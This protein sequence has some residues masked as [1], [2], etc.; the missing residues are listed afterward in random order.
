MML[1]EHD[2]G[3]G[4]IKSIPHHIGCAVK[5]IEDS[6]K[7][8]AGAMGLT[9]RTREIEVSSQNVSVCFLELRD[10]FYIEFVKPLN[11]NAKL[12]RYL[13]TGFYH[14]CF[15]VDDLI[16]AQDR[17]QSEQFFALPAFQSEA[18]AGGLCQFFVS[19]Q[20]HLIELA[21]ITSTDFTMF[22]QD[23]V[24]GTG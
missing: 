8:Y 20:S 24:A 11:E 19:P 15:L 13:G 5:N 22:F 6:C 7:I 2:N 4:L 18:F 16:A 21:E 3:A 23:N 12:S 1:I 9:R 17:L 10:S 14:I